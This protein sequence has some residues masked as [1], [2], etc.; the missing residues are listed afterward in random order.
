MRQIRES[1]RLHLQAGLSYNEVGRALRISKSAVGK[2]V[3][4]ARVAGVGGVHVD[5][6]SLPHRQLR[7]GPIQALL[8][9]DDSLP[10]R[11]LRKPP[12][13]PWPP[14]P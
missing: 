1:L 12:P 13:T 9:A 5:N 8:N 11:Q 2:Y 7:N 6:H 4:L 10:H 14:P 3:S